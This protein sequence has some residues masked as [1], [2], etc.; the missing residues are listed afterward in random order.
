MLKKKNFF[1]QRYSNFIKNFYHRDNVFDSTVSRAH[2]SLYLITDY[3]NA[4]RVHELLH[5]SS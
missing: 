1:F 4:G 5:C 3:E 2:L